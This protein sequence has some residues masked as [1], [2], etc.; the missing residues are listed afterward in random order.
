MI[1]AIN[2]LRQFIAENIRL[3][4]LLLLLS[5]HCFG[6]RSPY[7]SLL[8]VI[9]GVQLEG[10]D[11]FG[12]H[13]NDLVELHFDAR[14]IRYLRARR[15]ADVVGTVSVDLIPLLCLHANQHLLVQLLPHLFRYELFLHSE[16]VAKRNC[17]QVCVEEG[18]AE[19]DEV[20]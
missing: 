8:W 6:K 12:L 13:S 3:L 7:I 16:E 20:D 18:A 1:T 4:R 5:D 19:A 9:P 15:T 17:Q 10:W 11:P 2:V 14:S